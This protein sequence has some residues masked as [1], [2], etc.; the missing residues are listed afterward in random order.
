MGHNAD[1]TGNE[2]YI[3]KCLFL[4]ISCAFEPWW[5]K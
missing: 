2:V 4:V 3:Y 5:Q 1:M